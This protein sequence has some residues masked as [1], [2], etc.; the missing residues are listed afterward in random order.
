MRKQT[1]LS[2]FL[3]VLAA[4]SILRRYEY[5]EDLAV[6]SSYATASPAS[7]PS[8]PYPAAT[9]IVDSDGLEYVAPFE[10]LRRG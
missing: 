2:L 1:I 7:A 3:P 6:T 9:S 4:A 10:L 8:S 5:A